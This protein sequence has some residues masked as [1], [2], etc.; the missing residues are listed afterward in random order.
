MISSETLEV[1][2][3]AE[4]NTTYGKSGKPEGFFADKGARK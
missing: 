4:R 2:R 1:V 3:N